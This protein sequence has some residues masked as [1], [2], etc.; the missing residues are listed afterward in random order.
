MKGLRELAA[1]IRSLE[2][3][4]A[5]S[6]LV[7]AR[8]SSYRKPGARMVHA[9]G[10]VR[11]GGISAGCLETDV[12]ERVE[13]VLAAGVPALA[14]YDMGSDLDLVWGTGMGCQGRADV[15]MEPLEPG[16]LPWWMTWCLDLMETRGRGAL[17]TVWAAEAGAF[18]GP[19]DRFILTEDETQAPAALAEALRAV[20]ASGEPADFEAEGV[21]ALLEPVLPPTALWIVGAG[22]HARPLFRI[23][24]NLGWYLGLADHRPALATAARFPEADRILVGRAGDV[25]ARVPFD[26]RT[27]ALVVS[28]VF[29]EDKAALDALLRAP[30]GYLGL[31]GNRRRSERL[32]QEL[33]AERGPLPASGLAALHFPAGLDLGAE[34][35]EAIA[36]SMIAEAQAV[37]SGRKGGPLR[38]RK[39]PIHG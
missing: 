21:R 13:R 1:A 24:R 17:A 31:Q 26:A 7:R 2:G 23:A 22:D 28:H 11:A 5:L 12:L 30:L 32:L 29:E 25:L 8:G 3:P 4:A 35:P 19:G 6:T 15:L 37:L 10:G 33:E 34:S 18:A 27:G 16:R 20:E 39:L 9:P 38:D 36:L 14:T